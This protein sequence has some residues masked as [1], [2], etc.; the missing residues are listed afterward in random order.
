VAKYSAEIRQTIRVHGGVQ[1]LMSMV[2]DGRMDAEMYEYGYHGLLSLCS[3]EAALLDIVESPDVILATLRIIGRGLS[4]R[5]TAN[6]VRFLEVVTMESAVGR[7][8]VAQAPNLRTAIISFLLDGPR[9]VALQVI[10]ILESF[11]QDPGLRLAEQLS[12]EQTD[13]LKDALLRGISKGWSDYVECVQPACELLSMLEPT[14]LSVELGSLGASPV[15]RTKLSDVTREQVTGLVAEWPHLLGQHP[16]AGPLEA[17]F[18]IL[19][20]KP[21][22]AKWL[23]I[24]DARSFVLRYLRAPLRAQLAAVL[25]SLLIAILFENSIPWR[26][27]QAAIPPSLLTFVPLEVLVELVELLNSDN[28]EGKALYASLAAT[29]NVL[30]PLAAITDALEALSEED[31]RTFY[32]SAQEAG[33][34]IALDAHYRRLVERIDAV[35]AGPILQQAE[36]DN[37]ARLKPC[38]RFALQ[39]YRMLQERFGVFEP[40]ALVDVSGSQAGSLS[41]PILLLCFCCRKHSKYFMHEEVVFR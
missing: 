7:A 2:T 13:E 41:A 30:L 33:L 3:D 31:L 36:A 22:A 18:L 10:S 32:E 27:E 9:V 16:S 35:Q 29:E 17:L 12:D 4:G 28:P 11:F 6:A 26:Q 14:R 8:A 37:L 40:A 15:V 39:I 23:Q 21:E 19:L 34:Q 5:C 20:I 24:D 38:A 25:L 1:A